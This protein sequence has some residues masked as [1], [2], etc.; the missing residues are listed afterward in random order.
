LK[1]AA[2]EVT[3]D[4][5]KATNQEPYVR[6]EMYDYGVIMRLRY[7]TLATERPHTVHEITKRV[8]KEFARNNRVD[9]AIPYVYS[10]KRILTPL[11]SKTLNG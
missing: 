7:M 5:I 2:R 11:Q 10:S 4:I 3:S 1:N 9:F 6:S 8:F